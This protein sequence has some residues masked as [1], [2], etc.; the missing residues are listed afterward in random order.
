MGTDRITLQILMGEVQDFH[1]LLLYNTVEK[2]IYMPEKIV[3]RT[4]PPPNI[5]QAAPPRPGIGSYAPNLHLPVVHTNPPTSNP[6]P[7]V[8]YPGSR[9]VTSAAHRSITPTIPPPRPPVVHD[10]VHVLRLADAHEHE[11]DLLIQQYLG[12]NSERASPVVS[13]P[14]SRASPRPVILTT[15]AQRSTLPL[16]PPVDSST[17]TAQTSPRAVQFR[18]LDPSNPRQLPR[19]PAQ[20]SSSSSRPQDMTQVPQQPPAEPSNDDSMEPINALLNTFASIP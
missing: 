3:P 7:G 4:P 5:D 17:S 12:N 9:N 1:R 8:S 11:A 13:T 16:P 20:Q 6:Q 15:D 18:V 10:P 19:S 14:V 2:S